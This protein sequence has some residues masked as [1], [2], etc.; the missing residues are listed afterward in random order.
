MIISHAPIE[1][2]RQSLM[3]VAMK[4]VPDRNKFG[5]DWDLRI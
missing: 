4:L 3:Q 2:M 5:I 1:A